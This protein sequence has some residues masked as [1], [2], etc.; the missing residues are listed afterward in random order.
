MF[1]KLSGLN[2]VR[3]LDG[4]THGSM[5]KKNQVPPMLLAVMIPTVSK[6]KKS[7]RTLADT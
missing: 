3:Q 1:T 2:E 7:E 5:E 6:A 4:V